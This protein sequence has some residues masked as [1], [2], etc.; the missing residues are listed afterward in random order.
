M[1]Q[2]L[3]TLAISLLS[4]IFSGELLIHLAVSRETG[5][6]QLMASL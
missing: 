6:G 4:L 1:V 2:A 5:D 3:P